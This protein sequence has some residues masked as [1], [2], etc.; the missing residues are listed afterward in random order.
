MVLP[1]LRP[2]YKRWFRVETIGTHHIPRP[3][4]R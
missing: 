4:A 2:L 3:V 1:A